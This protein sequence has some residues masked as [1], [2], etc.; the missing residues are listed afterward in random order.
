MWGTH[1][2]QSRIF[3]FPPT[4]RQVICIGCAVS[5]CA[6]GRVVEQWNYVDY[7][8]LLQQFGVVPRMDRS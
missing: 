4:G 3:A 6:E 7:F 5:H 1:K 2:G 8:G